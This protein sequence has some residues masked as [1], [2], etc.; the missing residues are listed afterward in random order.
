[1]QGPIGQGL[2]AI[3]QGLHMQGPPRPGVGSSWLMVLQSEVV[4]A[5]MQGCK[6]GTKIG[7]HDRL[8]WHI[9]G[10]I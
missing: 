1:M 4:Q 7:L 10:K 2:Q 8:S 9:Q 6:L 5:R 3:A